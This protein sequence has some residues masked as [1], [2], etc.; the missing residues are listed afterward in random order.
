M[1]ARDRT[2]HEHTDQS[3]TMFALWAG[4]LAT[5]TALLS[6]GPR[7]EQPLAVGPKFE[8][9]QVRV[10]PSCSPMSRL[11]LRHVTTHRCKRQ[12]Y[13]AGAARGSGGVG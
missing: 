12:G 13:G 10:W 9:L 2:T 6:G 11:R 7:P 8:S 5:S 3:T 4:L 1:S